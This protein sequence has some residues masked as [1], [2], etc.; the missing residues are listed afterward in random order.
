MIVWY[1]KPWWSR[2]RL[3]LTVGRKEIVPTNVPEL[4]FALDF[5]YCC[6]SHIRSLPEWVFSTCIIQNP[7]RF[8]LSTLDSVHISLPWYIF[9]IPGHCASLCAAP[10]QSKSIGFDRI[11]PPQPH[12]TKIPPPPTRLRHPQTC[13]TAPA[14]KDNALGKSHA[15]KKTRY[16]L[17]LGAYCT[18]WQRIGSLQLSSAILG[19]WGVITGCYS[20]RMLMSALCIFSFY[21]IYL[22]FFYFINILWIINSD[23][24]PSRLTQWVK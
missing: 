10:M 23:H 19:G 20:R 8:R 1:L 4:H 2:W 14:M 15:Q 3:H 6:N 12:P 5:P 16:P 9:S 18:L 21:P 22:I 7:H 13:F 24:K 11:S 17:L